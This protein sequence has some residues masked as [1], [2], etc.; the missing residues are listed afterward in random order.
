MLLKKT[1]PC[2]ALWTACSM[3][4]FKHLPQYYTCINSLAPGKFEWNFRY[5]ILERIL[6]I[7]GLC[8]FC[9]IA[10]TWMSLDLIDDQST[11]VQVMTWCHQAKAIT[12]AKVDPD[13]C[14]HM[15]SLGHNVYQSTGYAQHFNGK[16]RMVAKL[17]NQYY[18]KW[19]INN[20]HYV[21]W[22]ALEPLIWPKD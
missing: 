21:W 10:L 15:A 13:S 8:I 9:E 14:R 4:L 20:A 17:L 19:T 3:F 5:V 11:L 1:I 7:D 18:T 12:W 22:S 16:C 2:L 6:V